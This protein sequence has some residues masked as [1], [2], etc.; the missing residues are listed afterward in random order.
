[1]QTI[2][3]ANN[4]NMLSFAP[5]MQ[6]ITNQQLLSIADAGADS[7]KRCWN[8]VQIIPKEVKIKHLDLRL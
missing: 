6:M 1:M 3:S 8:Q 2:T 5:E 7:N 4:T